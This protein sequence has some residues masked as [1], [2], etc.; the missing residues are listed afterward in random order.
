MIRILLVSFVFFSFQDSGDVLDN[1]EKSIKIGSARELVKYCNET[2]ELKIDGKSANYSRNQSEVVLRNFF[3][4]HPVRGYSYIHKG[5][6]PEGL[7]YSIGKYVFEGGSYRV[8]MRLKKTK[9]VYEI[10][11]LNFSKE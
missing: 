10:Y 7:K 3:Q 4:K 6:S 1:I 2:I 9:G 11:N 8:V 5:A